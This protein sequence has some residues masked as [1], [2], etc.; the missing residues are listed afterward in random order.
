MKSDR[1]SKQLILIACLL[2]FA[3]TFTSCFDEPVTDIVSLKNYEVP[4]NYPPHSRADGNYGEVL[5]YTKT[6]DLVDMTNGVDSIAIRLWYL[7][8]NNTDLQVVEL[9]RHNN[10]WVAKLSTFKYKYY[11]DDSVIVVSKNVRNSKPKSGWDKCLGKLF[12]YD[13]LTLPTCY[14]VPRYQI[15]QI[16]NKQVRV[17]IATPDSYKLYSYLSPLLN[18]PYV[19]E[20]KKMESIMRTIEDEFSF[21]RVE[22]F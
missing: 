17:E 9:F 18:E 2:F 13:L 16:A 20:A 4:I 15:N 7:Y 22:P 14:T 12:S 19:A 1:N 6:F 3:A 10:D 11:D 21:K 8:A 5:G